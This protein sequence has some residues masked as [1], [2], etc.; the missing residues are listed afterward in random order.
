[1]AHSEKTPA[2]LMAYFTDMTEIT[3]SMEGYDPSNAN[4]AVEAMRTLHASTTLTLD[5]FHT[6]KAAL[7]TGRKDRAQIVKSVKDMSRRALNFLKACGCGESKIEQAVS[8]YRDIQGYTTPSAV[9]S[10]EQGTN[11]SEEESKKRSDRQG[12][13]SSLV[14]NF[15]KLVKVLKA[16]PLYQPKEA[17]LKIPALESLVAT[18]KVMQKDVSAAEAK[19]AKVQ[20]KLDQSF[21]G[22]KKGVSDVMTDV[23]K[24]VLAAYGPTSP[25]YKSVKKIPV[26]RLKIT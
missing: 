10:G 14:E 25:E 13:Q 26:F 16:E 1:M 18:Y 15:L 4:L 11:S 22:Q 7:A 24:Y 17:D 8:I 2:R 23:K 3:S 21:N 5:E 19:W 12:S 9:E 6:V 20:A